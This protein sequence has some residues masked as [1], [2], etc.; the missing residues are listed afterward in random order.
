MAYEY[1]PLHNI[2]KPDN[3]IDNFRTTDIQ[4][5]LNNPVNIECQPSY[6]GTVN[7]IINDDV[8]PPRI[9]NNRFT[10]VE[11]NK[12]RVIK[13]NQL[14]QT[15]L[16]K[17]NYIDPQTRLFR[18]INKI[19][20]IDFTNISYHGQLKGGNYTFYVKYADNDYNK[21]DIVA[22][23]GSINIYKGMIQSVVSISG[24]LSDER[25][26]KVITIKLSN[27]DTSFSKIY[28]YYTRE[29]SD[30][31]GERIHETCMISKPYEITNSNMFITINGYEEVETIND[32][33][34]NIKYNLVTAVKTQTQVQNM[35]FFG[36]VQGVNV[37][38]KDLQ[39]ISLFLPVSLKQTE[40]SI[41]WLDEKYRVKQNNDVNQTEYY[42]PFTIYYKLGYWPNEIYRLGIVYIMNDDSLS[43]VFNL[44]GHK[45]INLD[46]YNFDNNSEFNKLFDNDGN[47]TYVPQDEFLSNDNYLD[48]TK[49]VF[50]NP[51]IDVYRNEKGVYPLYYQIDVSNEI[52]KLLRDKYN[53]KGYFIVRQK[54][55]PITLCQGLSIGVDKIS[56]TPM[57]SYQ[58]EYISESFINKS[59]V[60]TTD[61]SSRIIKSDSKQS[62]ALLTLDPSVNHQ[63]QSMFDG[64]EF[65]LEKTRKGI[66]KNNSRLY[67]L[68]DYSFINTDNVNKSSTI[69]VDEDV[70]LKYVNNHGFSTRAGTPEDVKQFSFFKDRNFA[71]KNN[72]LLRG[73][74]CP[75][76]GL[77]SNIE[78]NCIYNVRVQNY[79]SIFEK[80]YFSIRGNDNSSYFAISNRYEV[81]EID[82]SID[83][84]RGDC[85]TTTVSI[86][87]NRNFIDPDVPINETIVDANTWK[88]N[89]NG[90]NSTD[91]EQWLKI[92]RADVNA[93]PL[94]TWV[95]FKCLSNSNLGL[96]SEDRSN[97]DETAIMGNTRSFYPFRSPST[98]VAC[99]IGESWLLND[100]YNT[101]L[102][103]KRNIL[104]PNLPYI[105][106]LYDNRIMFS[107]VQVDDDFKNA[108]R[109][110][111]GLS[112]KDIDRQYGAIVKLISWGV[113][114]FCVFEHGLAII[115]INEKALI[116]T[117]TGQSIHMYGSGVIQNQVSLISPD[118][119]SIW[120]ESIIRTPVGIYGVDTSA[121]KIWRF[122]NDKGLELIS[123]AKIQR[124]LN[125]NILLDEKD[126]YPTISLKN[127]KSHF[128]NYKGDVM[129]TFYNDDEDTIWNICYN[130]RLDKWITRYSWTPLYSENINNVFYSLDK[131]RSETLA[132]I[133]DNR[134]TNS[135][136]RTNNNEWSKVGQS[137][138]DLSINLTPIGYDFYNEFDYKILNIKSS[139][140][141]ENGNE[142]DLII[143]SSYVL[144]NNNQLTLDK[145]IID[146]N[147]I[148][149]YYFQIKIEVSPK[150]VDNQIETFGS[151]FIQTIGV[152]LDI[153]DL[154]AN[155]QKEFD[156]LLINGFYVHGKA[157]IFNEINVKDNTRDNQILPTKWYD[158]QEPFEFEFVVN[159]LTGMHK[160]FNDLVVISNNVEPNS[161]DFE[162]IGDVYD[163]NKAGIYKQ[164][165]FPE[166]DEE[167]N[168]KIN[169]KQVSQQ[170]KENISI[171]YDHVLNEYHLVSNQLSKDIKK[172]GRMRGNIQYKE[173]SWYLVIEPIKFKRK[174]KNSNG[175]IEIDSNYSS[176]RIRDK[177]L[178]IK[179]KYSGENIAIITALKTFM[180]LSYS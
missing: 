12:F 21:T 126:K 80:D 104:S 91:A 129:F 144:L 87:L 146:Y 25:T 167:F 174:Y 42:N 5:D 14:Q 94:G 41:G 11:D 101:S 53:V 166:D 28:L 143:P 112:Y 136:I 131:K 78:D 44:R 173:D 140:I 54:R 20:I 39:N 27:I 43:P 109:I 26:E 89:Y 37:N 84:Y 85:Y 120:Q 152:I 132:Y 179:V 160:I 19:P 98:A 139:Y 130:E 106:D 96:R 16:Y 81:T 113:N 9:I 121:K 83:C 23:S 64:S 6:D 67:Y 124:Y 90:Y 161:F 102:S 100:G 114:L 32:E 116:S 7:L 48:N 99:K 125:D 70:P 74:F 172:Y 52:Q 108:Y 8:S 69:F 60:L 56:Y 51:N 2:L 145:N 49:G 24:T 175:D 138:N 141:N 61:Y 73:V 150:F 40:E 86:R 148:K 45:F 176:T 168:I 13:R 122:S 18:N 171:T 66:M 123:D 76:L 71:K 170:F 162:I 119:G 164:L 134:N 154:N 117:D 169:P 17:T 72:S 163:F 82:K 31:L 165:H 30:M 135:G 147:N 15:N 159:N 4:V 38:I 46:E 156:K 155:E 178:K 3:S 92:N 153:N 177:F 65:V 79:S 93:I 1:N 115:P 97:T 63:L 142:V 34:I 103:R 22:E 128:N 118:F 29:T 110:F 50:Q 95:T 133:Y 55:I 107:N 151:K 68:D 127:V 105:K 62:S 157:G 111:Q 36:N 158:K 180:T 47:M 149:L 10:V 137:Y 75:F 77:T 58:N 33:E 59:R 88:N 57:V 35:L